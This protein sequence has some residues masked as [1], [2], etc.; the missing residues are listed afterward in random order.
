[1]RCYLNKMSLETTIPLLQTAKYFSP[2][3]LKMFIQNSMLPNINFL[4]SLVYFPP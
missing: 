1:M 3:N 2:Y 4:N